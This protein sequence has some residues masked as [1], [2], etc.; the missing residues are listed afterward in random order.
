MKIYDISMTIHED[1]IVYKDKE[2]KRPHFNNKANYIN[3]DYYDTDL[4]MNL[5]TGTHFDAPLHMV[6]DGQTM[7]GYKLEKFITDVK[8]FNLE[9]LN[10]KITKEDLLSYDIKAGDFILLK[11]KNSYDTTFNF[12]FIYLD[13]SGAQYLAERSIIGVGIDALGIE[14]A[15]PEHETHK[16]LLRRGIMILEGLTLKEVEEGGYLM[17]ALPLKIKNVEAAP[18]RAVLVENL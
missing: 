4:Y 17:I 1:M 2:E 5:H 11:T 7:E 15:Q 14:R 16:V 18:T 8:V 10:N 3:A 12:D 13:Q 6:K 9:H